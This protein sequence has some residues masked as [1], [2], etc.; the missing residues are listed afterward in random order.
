MDLDDAIHGRRSI[1]DFTTDPVDKASILNLIDAAI[2][3]PSAVNEQPWSFYVVHDP[4]PLARIS[5]GARDHMLRTSPAAAMSER[6][7]EMLS[8]PANDV[9]HH[10]PL[11]IVI[12][13]HMQSPWS[14]E[15]CALAA[16]NLMLTAYSIGLGTCWIG[17]AQG[18][19][20]TP[21]GRAA[22][23]F[24]PTHRAVAP[25]VVGHPRSRPGPP[26]RKQADIHWIG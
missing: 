14:I 8:D 2:Q 16:Q 11:L 26:Q 24:S 10:A 13:S 21:D 22:I 4:G 18:W 6:F 20:Q 12:A 9:L 15:D 25:I 7:R 3:A 1:R 23:G 17:S 19:L 5:E